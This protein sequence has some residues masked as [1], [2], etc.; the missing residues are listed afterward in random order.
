MANWT[1]PRIKDL[2]RRIRRQFCLFPT[3]RRNPD[4][5]TVTTRWLEYG[6]VREE[7]FTFEGF[8]KWGRRGWATGP[9]DPWVN[10]PVS[11]GP[12]IPPTGGSAVVGP[13]K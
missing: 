8:L 6:Y 7:C 1:K 11:I 5:D 3:T 2:D 13:R 9:D 4:G 10:D 12:G